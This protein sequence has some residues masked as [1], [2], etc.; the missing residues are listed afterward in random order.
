ME[1]GK[2]SNCIWTNPLTV[3]HLN[4][5]VRP[6]SPNPAVPSMWLITECGSH[7]CWRGLVADGSRG[8]Q[9]SREMR[10]GRK[11]IQCE[12]EIIERQKAEKIFVSLW[13][14]DHKPGIQQPIPLSCSDILIQFYPGQTM[15]CNWWIYL[16][17]VWKKI[18]I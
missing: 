5:S 16:C 15:R 8:R 11:R 14:N 18:K 10:K 1:N 7:T 6:K 13:I 9:R 4:W 3:Q 17:K 2:S 12:V